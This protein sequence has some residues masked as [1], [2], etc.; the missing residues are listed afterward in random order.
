MYVFIS[1]AALKQE[2]TILTPFYIL[3]FCLS[4]SRCV[5]HIYGFSPTRLHTASNYSSLSVFKFLPGI[6]S[7]IF[8]FSC[9][10]H[11]NSTSCLNSFQLIFLFLSSS[12]L[13]ISIYHKTVVRLSF[14]TR[15]CQIF[16]IVFTVP[17]EMSYLQKFFVFIYLPMYTLLQ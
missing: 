2:P 3:H 14:V 5:I 4:P 9:V 6:S 10:F 17:H 1:R 12:F 8:S 11:S 15:V 7:S 16:S 13:F